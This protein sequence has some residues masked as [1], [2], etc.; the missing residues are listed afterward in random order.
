[1]LNIMNDEW[2]FMHMSTDTMSC[3][4]MYAEMQLTIDR[5]S[6]LG[7]HTRMCIDIW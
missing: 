5:D 2:I 4:Y 1:M 7:T 3:V 6:S